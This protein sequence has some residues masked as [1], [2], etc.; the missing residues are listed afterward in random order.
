MEHS[1]T[2]MSMSM[3]ILE[4]EPFRNRSVH[5]HAR[6]MAFKNGSIHEHSQTEF[7][8][9]QFMNKYVNINIVLVHI[10]GRGT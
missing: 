9:D 10:P 3:S 6:A 7:V 8:R 5:E 4:L 2:E 1:L